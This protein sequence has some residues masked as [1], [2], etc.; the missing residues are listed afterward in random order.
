[1]NKETEEFMSLLTDEKAEDLAQYVFEILGKTGE[2]PNPV[3]LLDYDFHVNR[4]V[5][6]GADEKKANTS[7][8][9][10]FPPDHF[11]KR[12]I[13]FLGNEAVD[14]D[15]TRDLFL[16]FLDKVGEAI[17]NRTGFLERLTNVVLGGGPP[18]M[19]FEVKRVTLTDLP[20]IDWTV[21]VHK[22]VVKGSEPVPVAADIM[23]DFL[24]TGDEPEEIVRRKK[25]SGDVRYANV[26]GVDK[27]KCFYEC[28]IVFWVD[29]S[30]R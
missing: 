13:E 6:I 9:F 11:G 18:V 7:F 4:G 2:E 16:G 12:I 21:T 26:N 19:G 25:E 15:L 23:Q 27:K 24:E 5:M 17:Q 14:A 1:M 22:T 30:V 10:D 29:Y 28:D 20:T 3:K 8:S